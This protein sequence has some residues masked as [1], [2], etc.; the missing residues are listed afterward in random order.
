M[1]RYLEAL[2]RVRKSSPL[3]QLYA[4]VDGGQF[5]DTFKEAFPAN[6]GRSLFEGSTDEPL[7]HAGPWL[8]DVEGER[9]LCNQLVESETT[10]PL[11]S[12]II[13]SVPMQGLLQL[14][15]LRMETKLPSGQFA[16]L[17][18]FDPRVLHRLASTLT[19]PQREEF[20]TGI[21]EWHFHATGQY[22]HIGRNH[23]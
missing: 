11:C 7:A 15:Q 18:F 14:L 22:F 12:W 5:A 16:V 20:F 21:D 8:V 9:A 6:R 10:A 4:L 13:T 1:E 19:P 23:A 2:A 3:A 17:R